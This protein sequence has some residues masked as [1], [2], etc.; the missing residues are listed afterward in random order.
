MGDKLRRSVGPQ[1]TAW[2]TYGP[3]RT[4][5]Q[6]QSKLKVWCNTINVCWLIRV[7]EGGQYDGEAVKM[8]IS[9]YPEVFGSLRCGVAYHLFVPAVCEIYQG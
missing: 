7:I 2:G 6:H 8:H 9:L 1:V 5:T 3:W 4:F